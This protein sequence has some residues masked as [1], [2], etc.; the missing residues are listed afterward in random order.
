[1]YITEQN[2]LRRD[3]VTKMEYYVT[4]MEYYVTYI[5]EV[6]NKTNLEQCCSRNLRKFYGLYR[7]HVG[8]KF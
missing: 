8:F 2:I 3:Y 1:V 6:Q 4:K 7:D 5:Y